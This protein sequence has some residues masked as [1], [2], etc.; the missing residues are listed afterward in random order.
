MP[1]QPTGLSETIFKERYTIHPEET[2]IEASRRLSKH[3]ASAEVNGNRPIVEEAFYEEIVENR[4]MPGGRIWYGSGRPRGQLLNC[5]VVPTNDS[6]EGWG[7]TIHDVIVIS[8][9]GGGVGINCSPIRP[10]GSRIN[11]T[12]G[13]A[14]GAVSLMQ[15][16]NAVGDVLVG[17][18]GRR[19]ALMLDLNITHPDIIEF[20]DKKLDQKEL[21]NANV[22]VIIDKRLPAESFIK[23]VRKGEDFDLMFGGTKA[24]KANA[25][26]IW[27][28]IKSL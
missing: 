24:G 2:W 5:F 25:K 19:L 27:E 17:G 12:G 9:M 20:L 22:S 13:I 28:K 26:E 16:I 11:G 21:T 4:F 6:R 14:T 3:V 8:G 18:G 1:Y 7:T 10:R 15:M 23:K